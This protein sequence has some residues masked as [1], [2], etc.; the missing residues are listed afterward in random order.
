MPYPLKK[1]KTIN[2]YSTKRQ[3]D[4]QAYQEGN[5]DTLETVVELEKEITRLKQGLHMC[6]ELAMLRDNYGMIES[7]AQDVLDG[8]E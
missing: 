5:S 6:K 8:K 4:E 2:K 1:N 7:V 3:K